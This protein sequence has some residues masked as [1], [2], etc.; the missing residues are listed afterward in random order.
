MT[1]KRTYVLRSGNKEQEI[2]A[3]PQQA[4]RQA[5]RLSARGNL[6]RTKSIYEQPEQ[7]ILPARV[8]LVDDR[9]KTVMTCTPTVVSPGAARRGQR[10]RYSFAR[11]TIN[12]A[13]K[14]L[15][16]KTKRKS[17]RSGLGARRPKSVFVEWK[18]G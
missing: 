14:K 9:G 15:I 7:T 2:T 10:V 18:E 12:E 11:C 1:E 6:L 4:A 3:T 17:K 16:H 8:S 5:A 13:F